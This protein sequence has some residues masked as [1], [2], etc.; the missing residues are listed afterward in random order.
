MKVL[1]GLKLEPVAIAFLEA[2]PPHV[3]RV[4]VVEPAGCAYWRSAAEGKV[5]YTEASD[6]YHCPIG[7]YTHHI[8]LPPERAKE[9][10]ET[11][12]FMAGIGYVR[13]EE[14]PGIPVLP[15]TPAA[16]IYAPLGDTPV[17]PDVVLFWGP[18]SS[19]MLLQEAAIHAGVAAS[20]NTLGRPTCM[21]LPAALAHGIVASTGCVGNR[22]Y[23]RVQDGELYA[24][25]P[26]RDVAKL[27]DSVATVRSAN[28]SL[29]EYHEARRQQL[30]SPPTV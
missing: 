25:V 21:A 9:L 29:L 16:V 5:F 12:G 10:E 3:P 7:A 17:D 28:A 22:V 19:V 27:A 26:G 24:A 2:P 14:V 1:L 20:L 18:A 4:G 30:T 13:M 23:T 11:L 8:A 6:H 15:A